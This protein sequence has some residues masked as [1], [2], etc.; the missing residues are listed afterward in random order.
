ML[1]KH[2]FKAGEAEDEC[3]P[4]LEWEEQQEAAVLS[5]SNVRS[6]R[7]VCTLAD[8]RLSA[9]AAQLSGAVSSVVNPEAASTSLSLDIG[10][11]VQASASEGDERLVLIPRIESWGGDNRG[12]SYRSSADPSQRGRLGDKRM[13]QIDR[14]SCLGTDQGGSLSGD[15]FVYIYIAWSWCWW[16]GLGDMN[17]I[18]GDR[19]VLPLTFPA[20]S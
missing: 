20:T 10:V 4:L 17:C 2:I 18:L 11:E 19:W 9:F 16:R 8:E 13:D 15:N 14:Y 12:A 3:R 1:R 5:G 7:P 6:P